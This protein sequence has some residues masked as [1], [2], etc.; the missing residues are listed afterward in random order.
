MP[1]TPFMGVRISWLMLARKR[2]LARLAASAPSRA[3]NQFRL[4]ALPFGNL[5][6]DSDDPNQLPGLVANGKGPVADPFLLPIGR[7]YAVFRFERF[8]LDLRRQQ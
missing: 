3:P 1:I 8:S 6:R 2:L 5:L 7:S 4:V